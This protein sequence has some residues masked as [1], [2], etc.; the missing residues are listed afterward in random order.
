MTNFVFTPGLQGSVPGGS[1]QLS[2]VTFGHAWDATDGDTVL[3]LQNAFLIGAGALSIGLFARGSNINNLGIVSGAEFGIEVSQTLSNSK[4][5][6]INGASGTISG[7]T[8]GI[9]GVFLGNNEL[10]T[11]E[12]HGT[13]NATGAGTNDSGDGIKFTGGG[14]TKIIN[15]G[16][17]SGVNGGFAISGPANTVG[18]LPGDLDLTNSGALIGGIAGL[19]NNFNLTSTG[20]TIAGS[21]DI[22]TVFNGST[23]SLSNTHITGHIS[24][25]NG[26]SFGGAT[27]DI[28]AGTIVDGFVGTSD[29]AISDRVTMTGGLVKGSIGTQGGDDI[30]IISGGQV[31]FVDAGN[32]NDTVS[33]VGGTVIESTDLGAG[34]DTFTG[35]DAID[36]VIGNLGDDTADL[37]GGNDSFL[38]TFA[39]VGTDGNDDINGGA[40]IDT[41]DANQSS[42]AVTV[43]IDND[44]A[45]GAGI[46]IDHIL[47]FENAN[48]SAFADTLLGDANANE[49]HG[50]AGA[51]IIKGFAGNDKIYGDAGADVITGGAGKDICYGGADADTFVFKTLADSTV[52]LTGR[53]YLLDFTHLSDK[54]D[55]SAIDANAGL[56]GNQAF[57]FIGLGAFT[58]V[59]GQLHLFANAAGF[60]VLSGDVDG[61]TVMDFAINI[62]GTGLGLTGADFIL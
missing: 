5:N 50:N 36:K 25:I 35:G 4:A 33:T 27:I 1:S 12:N 44:F 13:I 15:T 60:T 37:G 3:V 55:L 24:L 62:K 32:G 48:G 2:N 28:N 42:A 38:A 40:G 10:L 61:D 21:V 29:L 22:A 53:D 41:Y 16:T 45:A 59:A 54:I 18:V 30:I 6:I 9:W 46:G 17:I 56:A 19:Y 47:N 52:A 34:N 7:G 51:D 14:L 49:F 57:S 43:D 11:I 8:S 20:G 58:G 23:V 26:S 31:G 39:S